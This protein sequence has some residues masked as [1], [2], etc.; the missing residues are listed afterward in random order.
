M[1][2]DTKVGL[3]IFGAVVIVILL[4]VTLVGG[5]ITTPAGHLNIVLQ[6]G[7]AVGVR[8]AGYSV[9]MPLFEGLQLISLQ[10]QLYEEPESSAGTRDLQEVKTTIKIN[11]HLDKNYAIDVYNQ[12][13]VSYMNTVGHNMIQETLKEI[14]AKYPAEEMITKRAQVK[15]D[16][17]KAITERL[18]LRHI[19]VE[20]VSLT[21]FAFSKEFSAAIESKVAAAQDVLKAENKLLQI[22]VEAEQAV[23]QAKGQA[24]AIKVLQSTLTREYLQYLY[25]NKLAPDAKI[26]VVPQGMP[27][28][29][30]TD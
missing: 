21:D 23:A 1:D 17:A 25:I 5:I 22:R 24:E 29:L 14:T 12:L 18:A 9:K 30:P 6:G 13:G 10:T 15:D 19:V 16:I 11:Y 7:K 4:I 20:T 3:I 27:I 26:V 8:E 28:V 2:E